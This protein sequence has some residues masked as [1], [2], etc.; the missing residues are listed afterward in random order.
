[1]V[2]GEKVILASGARTATP[3]I[4]DFTNDGTYR[5]VKVIIPITA[6]TSTP[7]TTF[8]VQGRDAQGNLF[9][10]LASTAQAAT[11]TVVLT[12]HPDL[13]GAAN[14]VA[15]DFLPPTWTI[16]AAHGNANSMT[17]SISVVLLS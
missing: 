14:S 17:Y 1:M 6:V 5:G 16:K 8:T 4:G 15:K 13:T 10:I 11:G 9:D 2:L 7:S 12:V 3:T